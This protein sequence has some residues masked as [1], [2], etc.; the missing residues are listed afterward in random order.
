MIFMA[1]IISTCFL[2]NLCMAMMDPCLGRPN[3]CFGGNTLNPLFVAESVHDQQT[4]AVQL[5]HNR[6][7]LVPL[8]NAGF[9]AAEVLLTAYKMKGAYYLLNPNIRRSGYT[10]IKGAAIV[11]TACACA[12]AGYTSMALIPEETNALIA[13]GVGGLTQIGSGCLGAV[14]GVLTS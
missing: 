13:I 8:F 2:S 1:M 5:D 10:I 7:Q 11:A 3:A 9:C 14:V 6:M 4:H 12:Y